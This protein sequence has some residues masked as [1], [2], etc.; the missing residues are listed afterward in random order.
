MSKTFGNSLCKMA[1]QDNRIVAIT[2]AMAWGQ[3]LWIFHTVFQSVFD[4]G[5]AEQH[6][7]TFAAGMAIQ[8]YKPVVAIYSTFCSVLMIKYCMMYAFKTC[9]LSFVWT[10]AG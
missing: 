10:A 5:I 4:V 8:G 1:S 9:R 3:A 2:A 7:V 6:A